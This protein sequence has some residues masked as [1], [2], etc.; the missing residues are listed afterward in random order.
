VAVASCKGL[1][2]SSNG[3]LIFTYLRRRRILLL[4]GRIGIMYD[5]TVACGVPTIGRAH[6]L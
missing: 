3:H 5:T 2:K 4:L 1:E 6:N